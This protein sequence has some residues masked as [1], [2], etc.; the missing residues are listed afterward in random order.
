MAAERV[1]IPARWVATRGECEQLARL[2][3]RNDPAAQAHPLLA[4]WRRGVV[5]DHLV[6]W[7][8]GELAIVGDRAAPGGVRLVPIKG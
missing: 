7:V 2:L 4:T 3:D 1:K 5:G 8:R 6:A